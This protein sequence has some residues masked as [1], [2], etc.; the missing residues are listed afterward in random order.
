LVRAF[1]K[2]ELKKFSF[3][4]AGIVGAY[5][6]AILINYGNITLTQDYAVHTIR[7][8]NDIN[9]KP[10]GTAATA[11]TSG[12]DKDYITHWSYGKGESFTFISPYAKGSSS[13]QLGATRFKDMVIDSDRSREDVNKIMS[14]QNRLYY[15]EQPSS[16]GPFYLGVIMILIM[17]LGLV[18][19]DDRRKWV[20]FGVA[21]LALLLSWGKNF[22]GLTDFFLDYVPAYNKFRT[23]TIILV[24]VELIVPVIGVLFLEKLIQ[25]RDEIK[26]RK[27]P[28]LAVSGGFFVLLLVL[29]FG[30]LGDFY[31]SQVERDYPQQIPQAVRSQI[32]SM[33]PADLA[34]NQI[35]KNNPQQIQQIV[36]F[37]VQRYDEDLMLIKG[38]R[39]DIYDTSINRSLVVTFFGI[40]L[41]AL[42]FYTTLSPYLIVGGLIIVLLADIVPVDRNYL[43]DDLAP[44]GQMKYWTPEEEG[45][46]PM[47][48]T[49]EDY[50]IM[51]LESIDPDVKKAITN[52][53]KLGKAKADELEYAGT[54]RKRVI[55]SYTFSELNFATNYR[56]YD[57]QNSWGSSRA[58]YFHKNFGGY[59]GAKLRNVQ[60]LF[61]FQFPK[62]NRSIGEM[63]ANNVYHMLNIKYIIGNGKATLNPSAMGP[64]WFVQE[65]EEHETPVNELRA[66]GSEFKLANAGQG[67]LI[68]NDQTVTEATVYGLEKLQYLLPTNDTVNIGVDHRMP[69]G[70]K[71]VLVSDVKGRLEWIMDFSVEADT[72]NSFLKMVSVEVLNTFDPTQEAVMLKSEAAKLSSK[73]FTGKG[74]VK[75]K[76]YLPNEIK[77][78]TDSKSKQFLVFSEIY[79]PDGWTATVDGKETEILKTNYLLRGI[80]VGAG[81]HEVVLKFE[82]P[83]LRISNIIAVIGTIVLLIFIV[84]GFIFIKKK[85]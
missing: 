67:K 56:V 1:S 33:S 71:A 62:S 68:I 25:D 70:R 84:L 54:H 24:L 50:H 9:L 28:F 4:T 35:D 31:S 60:N 23:V 81:A 69:M 10:D 77:Y 64:A 18:Y 83:A 14:M 32:A 74:S 79:Y 45:A 16:A 72:A 57:A 43:S 26:K 27:T 75:M 52:G 15:A 42:F 55:D 63:L 44:N 41:L 20:L 40:A 34:Q 17:I 39:Q 65:I 13:E 61:E 6:L 2:K 82:I 3:A 29:K 49:S 78:A 19:I 7:G 76:S 36:D 21:V 12:L 37:Q 11:N 85:D 30:G 58:S 51:E 80:E 22:M 66:L 8:G 5:I 47:V 53:E 38:V 73:T 59:H 46:Y 48:A